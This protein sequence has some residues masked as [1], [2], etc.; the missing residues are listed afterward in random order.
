MKPTIKVHKLKEA[1]NSIKKITDEQHK[2]VGMAVAAATL[3]IETEAKKIVPVDTSTLKNSISS[4]I[5]MEA[6]RGEVTANAEYATHVEYG[7]VKMEAQPFLF[8]AFELVRPKFVKKIKKILGG[9]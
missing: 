4:E 3:E 8:P 2:Q 6:M 9:K 5:D 1:V 7:T